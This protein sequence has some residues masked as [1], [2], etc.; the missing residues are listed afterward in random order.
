MDMRQTLRVHPPNQSERLVLSLDMA[1]GF[2]A[3]GRVALW[4]VPD[5]SFTSGQRPPG[6]DVLSWTRERP[7][8]ALQNTDVVLG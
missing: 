5:L 1:A 8:T 4:S 6:R 3:L 7:A 2:G